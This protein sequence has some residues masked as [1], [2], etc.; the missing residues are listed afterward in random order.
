MKQKPTIL[1]VQFL[2]TIILQEVVFLPIK[3]RLVIGYIGSGKTRG[4]MEEIIKNHEQNNYYIVGNL[5]KE[6]KSLSQSIGEEKI[7]YTSEKAAD[8]TKG[9]MDIFSLKNLN[10]GMEL[11][12]KIEIDI[13]NIANFFCSYLEL[14]KGHQFQMLTSTLKKMYESKKTE[15]SLEPQIFNFIDFPLFLSYLKTEDVAIY[16]EFVKKEKMF[17]DESKQIQNLFETKADLALNYNGVNLIN[18]DF[19]SDDYY[20]DYVVLQIKKNLS[21]KKKNVIVIEEKTRFLENILLYS[22]PAEEYD[23]EIVFISPE[24][25]SENSKM[26]DLSNTEIISYKVMYAG[27][28]RSLPKEWG[29]DIKELKR[30]T[31]T[32]KLGEYVKINDLIDA[33][34]HYYKNFV[35]RAF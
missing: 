16:N 9:D 24:I 4:M 28:E 7:C 10:D 14:D 3:K 13:N 35:T 8:F 15:I 6:Y 2:M 20:L 31:R 27:Y 18:T 34:P 33:D 26:L 32:L 17:Y 1:K 29:I 19:P 22:F 25:S 21:T 23:I 11:N 12:K 5:A 30:I